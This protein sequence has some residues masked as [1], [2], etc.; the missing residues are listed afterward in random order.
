MYADFD[1][2]DRGGVGPNEDQVGPDAW[3]VPAY[4]LFDTAISHDFSF[5][6]FNATLSGRINNIFDTEYI[7]D[8]LDGADSDALTAR[9]YYGF[10]RTFSVGLKLNF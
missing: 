9:V 8:A 2:S 5:G 10:G 7:A 4:G 1:P 3:Q 6:S